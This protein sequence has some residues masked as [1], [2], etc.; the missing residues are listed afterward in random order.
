MEPKKDSSLLI[1]E[2]SNSEYQDSQR[3]TVAS[4]QPQVLLYV[5]WKAEA[6]GGNFMPAIMLLEQNKIHIYDIVDPPTGNRL[7]TLIN[8][9]I[10]YYTGLSTTIMLL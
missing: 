6:K 4:I 5:D 1:E 2:P 9:I 10:I 3:T 8:L 7:I